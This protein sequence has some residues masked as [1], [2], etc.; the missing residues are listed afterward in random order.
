MKTYTFTIILMSFILPILSLVPPAFSDEPPLL[1][2]TL[3]PTFTISAKM[4]KYTYNAPGKT[5]PAG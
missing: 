2:K 5:E 4:G 3:I 1:P